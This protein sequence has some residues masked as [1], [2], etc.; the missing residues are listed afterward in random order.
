MTI[1]LIDTV[2]SNRV[3]TKVTPLDLYGVNGKT[4][5]NT[6]LRA[7]YDWSV[8]ETDEA[9]N[10]A[11]ESGRIIMAHFNEELGKDRKIKFEGMEDML[12]FRDAATKERNVYTADA[13][14][15]KAIRSFCL[16]RTGEAD[17][18][19]FTEADYARAIKLVDYKPTKAEKEKY[20][21]PM[22]VAEKLLGIVEQ[23]LDDMAENKT[24]KQQEKTMVGLAPFRKACE[25]RI[26]EKI[27]KVMLKTAEQI[28]AERK[29]KNKARRAAREKATKKSAKKDTAQSKVQNAETE[30]AQVE[31]KAA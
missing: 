3:N 15:L 16:Y 23:M 26:A 12:K 4:E 11:F 6:F 9:R 20:D 29:E 25:N 22:D 21:L 31:Q 19:S 10:A 13:Q 14:Q 5:W 17:K 7:L 18:A 27:D 30:T 1:N 28:E 24:A 2:R 8:T